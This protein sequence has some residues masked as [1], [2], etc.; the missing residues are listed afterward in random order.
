MYEGQQ[1]WGVNAEICILRVEGV[2]C[3]RYFLLLI[4]KCQIKTGIN[5]IVGYDGRRHETLWATVMQI[6]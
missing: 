1:K 2:N 6:T 3:S 5:S 4:I